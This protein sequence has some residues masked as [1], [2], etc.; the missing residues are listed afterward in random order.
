[1]YFGFV[2]GLVSAEMGGLGFCGNVLW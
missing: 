2:F 1:M